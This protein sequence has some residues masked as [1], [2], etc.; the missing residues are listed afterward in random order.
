MDPRLTPATNRVAHVSLQARL[1]RPAYTKGEPCQVTAPLV[2]LLRSPNGA[3]ERQLWLGDEFLVIDRDQGQA[4]GRAEKDGFC[5]WLPQAALGPP[6]P[7]THWVASPGTHL[8]PEPR[9]QSRALNALPMGARLQVTGQQGKY[10]ETTIGFVPAVHLRA[11]GDWHQD[12]VTVAETFLHSPYLWGGNSRAGIDCSGLAQIAL[13]ACGRA[14]PG[15]SDLQESLGT[16]LPETAALQR[17]DLMFWQG[18]VALV[19]DASRLIHANGQTMSVA[20]EGTA[21]CIARIKAQNGGPLTQ[22]R[23]P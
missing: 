21:A 2:D 3:R 1:D 12:P 7:L 14:C 18:H 5:G 10:A 23:R 11:L 19:V 15:D 17:G 4:F 20:Y 16:A 13:L 6:Q 9:T 22:R 8:Y